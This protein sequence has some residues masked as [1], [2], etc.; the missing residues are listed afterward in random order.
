M[1]PDKTS[2]EKKETKLAEPKAPVGLIERIRAEGEVFKGK[3]QDDIDA[4][5]EPQKTQLWK[6]IFRV[7]HDETPRSRSLGVLSNVFLHLHPARINRDAVS[8]DY[9]W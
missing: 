2:L 6:S 9:T 7:K 5:K 1:E 4:A 8:Y 3:L